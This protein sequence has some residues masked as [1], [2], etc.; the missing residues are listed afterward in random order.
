MLDDFVVADFGPVVAFNHLG[1][2]ARCCPG[3]GW[4]AFESKRM[5]RLRLRFELRRVA[6]AACR[7]SDIAGFV[8][9]K[10]HDANDCQIGKPGHGSNEDGFSPRETAV[11]P[12]LGEAKAYPPNQNNNFIAN[13]NS[14]G[15]LIC[16]RICPV[17]GFAAVVMLVFGGP[18]CTR[19]NRL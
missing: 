17:V 7:A 10:G 18:N 2:R 12:R 6:V 8:R 1:H 3:R 9:G 19:L 11:S 4:C 14:R 16:V 5:R 15:V 13:C